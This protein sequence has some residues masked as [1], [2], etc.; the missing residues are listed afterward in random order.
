MTSSVISSSKNNRKFHLCI[1][2]FEVNNSFPYAMLMI[3]ADHNFRDNG[4]GVMDTCS[5]WVIQSVIA[6]MLLQVHGGNC[7]NLI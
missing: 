1:D 4:I 5:M 2:K 3:R 6:L 7:Y